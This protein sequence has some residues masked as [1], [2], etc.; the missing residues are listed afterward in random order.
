LHGGE[1]A[2]SAGEF[3]RGLVGGEIWKRKWADIEPA[4]TDRLHRSNVYV[5]PPLP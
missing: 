5:D 1:Y 4:L 2:E 3:N